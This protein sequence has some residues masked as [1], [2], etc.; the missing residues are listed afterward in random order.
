[1][2]KTLIQNYN[3]NG[4]NLKITNPNIFYNVNKNTTTTNNIIIKRKL[5]Y[6]NNN[7][8]NTRPLI[9][10]IRYPSLIPSIKI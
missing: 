1:M 5:V 6:N 4:M 3:D 10:T 7:N 8:N 2:Y 9:I